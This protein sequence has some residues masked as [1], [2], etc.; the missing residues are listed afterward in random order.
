MTK[1]HVVRRPNGNFSF[2]MTVP[3]ELRKNI[4]K[5]EVWESLDTTNRTIAN[6]LAAQKV[7]HWKGVF[8]SYE[9]KNGALSSKLQQERAALQGFEFYTTQALSDATTKDKVAML[10]DANAFLSRV[11]NP[12][13]EQ[14]AANSGVVE[15]TLS[16][17]ELFNRFV[18]LNAAK[19]GEASTEQFRKKRNRY[20][21]PITDFKREMGDLD[22]LKLTTKDAANYSA[23]IAKRIN[24]GD[25]VS[26]TGEHKMVFLKKMVKKVFEND[27]PD[28]KSPFAN[29]KV[30]H[31]GNDS[32]SR[33]PFTEQEIILLHQK[34]ETSAAN[35]EMKAIL[36][37]ME[38]TGATPSEIVFLHES[39]FHLDGEVPYIHVGPN[40]NRKSLKTDNRPRDIPLVGPALEA[41]KK[42]PK[43][44]PRYCRDSGSTALSAI[45]NKFIQT[46]SKKTCYSYRHRFIDWLREVDGMED[47]WLKSIVGHDA[48]M[49]GRY[50][51]GY[52][53]RK[54]KDAITKAMALAE[55]EQTELIEK[56]KNE[57]TNQQPQYA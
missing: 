36:T 13:R 31:A 38:Y 46:V 5:R 17:D 15:D 10:F 39:D 25:F 24:R 22:V 12:S 23:N 53:L 48:S 7:L 40:P 57:D 2:R 29:A 20:L 45:G 41:A 42:F 35:D 54:K 8:L 27:Y 16:L 19:M 52:S 9:A 43:G 47:S 33:P 44:F 1:N 51:K 11:E 56:M 50:G 34:M 55:K 30:E 14:L 21:E 26:A 4:G 37:L 49:T 6:A 28:R 32:T 3:K 18:E